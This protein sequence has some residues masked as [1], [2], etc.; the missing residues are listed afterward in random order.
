M[1]VCLC[2]QAL[3]LT[4]L[5]PH[6]VIPHISSTLAQDDD[7]SEG[8]PHS[9]CL[10]THGSTDLTMY[11]DVDRQGGEFRKLRG[12]SKQLIDLLHASQIELDIEPDY[13]VRP[14]FVRVSQTAETDITQTFKIKERVEEKEGI[15]PLQQRLIFGGK[16][17]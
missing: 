6:P 2:Q 5:N 12:C 9:R 13:T 17:M 4:A 1:L 15:P 3:T 8:R 11:A 16:Q 14:P 10:Y 7:Q